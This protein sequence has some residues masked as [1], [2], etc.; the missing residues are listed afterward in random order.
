[1]NVLY[2]KYA[3]EVSKT[4]SINKAAENL[5]MAQPNLS[6][7][8][9]ELES[10]LG[11]A[12]FDRTT[13]GMTL[14]AEGEIF[15]KNAE[16][17]LRRIESLE[18]M[19]RDGNSTKLSF[20]ITIPRSAYISRATA[21]FFRSMSE[22]GRYELGY[23]ETDITEAF[24]AVYH[25]VCK[26]GIIRV[27]SQYHDFVCTFLE[28]KGIRF[29]TV[30]EFYLCPTMSKNHPLAIRDTVTATDMQAYAEIEYLQK[31]LSTLLKNDSIREESLEG[32][33][34]KIIV[35]NRA[36]CLDV[37]EANEMAFIWGEPLLPE[38]LDKQGLVQKSCPE[39][40]KCVQDILIYRKDYTLTKQDKQFITD[41]C[42]VK[43]AVL[44]DLSL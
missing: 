8:I 9:K 5:Y 41:L 34:R 14:T 15:L 19:F 18:T 11:I 12:I 31:P 20:S 37:L 21:L 27:E 42:N 22:S 2:L 10:S 40:G 24:H 6:R 35:G 29:E 30:A 25:S 4:G 7:S 16:E 13:K 26:L 28:E 39:K 32:N 3:L 1:M 38:D 23:R 36:E 33:S 44:K 17:I 43:R